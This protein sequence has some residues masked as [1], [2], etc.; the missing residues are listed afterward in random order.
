MTPLRKSRAGYALPAVL[1][2]LSILTLVF[3]SAIAALSSLH[4]EAKGALDGAEFQRAAMSAE[5]HAAFIVTTEPLA[6]D[7]IRVGGVRL[8]SAGGAASAGGVAASSGV[9]LKLDDR[10]YLWTAP[11]NGRR[12]AISLQDGAG[13][14]N[15]NFS[16]A[17]ALMRLFQKAGTSETAAQ[18]L[19]DQV[20]D[21]LDADSNRRAYGAEGPDYAAANRPLPPNGPISRLQDVFGVL[22][23]PRVITAVRWRG[24]SPFLS[25][26]PQSK[27]FNINT[28]PSP[29][30]Q[31]VLNLTPSAA[32]QV[33]ARREQ[34]PITDLTQ[35]G[36]PA[37]D[38]A[39]SYTRPN[40]RFVFT[41][42][43]PLRQT[44]YRSQMALTP[45]D[46]ARPI[47]MSVADMGKLTPDRL[48]VLR[49]SNAVPFPD[50]LNRPAGS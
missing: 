36:L 8:A 19:R 11:D 34:M 25:A 30:L 20:L 42:I 37:G 24:M 35:V 18:S 43:D 49:G 5:A 1:T 16:R 40:G 28:A 3:M 26:D 31:M 41:F 50:P 39:N 33:I 38:T 12:Y 22:D 2:L 9:P 17:D 44:T 21:F 47:R 32:A 23:W 13:L 46:N 6:E 45:D 15:L 27:S 48:A 4:Q 10:P 14:M 7:R 29:V